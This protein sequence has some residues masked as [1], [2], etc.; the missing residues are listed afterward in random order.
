MMFNILRATSFNSAVLALLF[1]IYAACLTTNAN[2][3]D[4]RVSTY[5]TTQCQVGHSCPVHVEIASADGQAFEGQVRFDGNLIFQSANGSVPQYRRVRQRLARGQPGI[6]TMN[7]TITT[8]G[9]NYTCLAN[10]AVSPLTVNTFTLFYDIPF[11]FQARS[12]THNVT[13]RKLD[14]SPLDAT[15]G[16]NEMSGQIDISPP[17]QRNFQLSQ[18]QMRL[19]GPFDGKCYLGQ[20]CDFKLRVTNPSSLAMVGRFKIAARA[21][22]DTP[23]RAPLYAHRSNLPFCGDQVLPVSDC[24]EQN[25]RG[26]GAGRTEELSLRL[27]MPDRMAASALGQR[28]KICLDLGTVRDP[29]NPTLDNR[30]TI[31]ACT[32]FIPVAP[33]R[34]I[35]LT[36]SGPDVCESQRSCHFLI[37]FSN[38]SNASI[39]QQ[40]ILRHWTEMYVGGRQTTD[41]FRLLALSNICRGATTTTFFCQRPIL[42][43][44]N[45]GS[46]EFAFSISLIHNHLLSAAEGGIHNDQL[47]E[48]RN[49]IQVVGG[50]QAC[51]R[52]RVVKPSNPNSRND[53]SAL[54]V[55]GVDGELQVVKGMENGNFSF[56]DSQK[57]QI[58]IR[59][60]SSTNRYKVEV[61]DVMQRIDDA[62]MLK[63]SVGDPTNDDKATPATCAIMP[64]SSLCSEV[65]S[66]NP[67]R[68]A[69]R[70][71]YRCQVEIGPSSGKFFILG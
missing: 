15:P 38:N 42:L 26:F 71:P 13:V 41:A 52:V 8:G 28:Q 65:S 66:T 67:C 11:D 59:N 37:K 6:G 46:S 24:I 31:P 18:L 27:T 33:D 53:S 32:T 5:R 39:R 48:L 70:L 16:N 29:I 43:G 47:I 35:N 14:L 60:T 36:Y 55:A 10:V 44:S 63:A 3:L 20:A 64:W 25:V 69:G 68:G 4:L 9:R 50:K 1:V 30:I 21:F 2:A 57:F 56:G 62:T 61:Y 34:G 49:C 51:K 40:I 12:I 17:Q 54:P 58:G 7:C 19:S 45:Q 22:A 23:Q